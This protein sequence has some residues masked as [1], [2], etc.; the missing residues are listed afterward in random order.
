MVRGRRLLPMV[1]GRRLLPMV[2]GRLLSLATP[3][4]QLIRKGLRLF[5]AKLMKIVFRIFL[6]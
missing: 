6:Y 5:G 3:L 4:T 1:R 2:R